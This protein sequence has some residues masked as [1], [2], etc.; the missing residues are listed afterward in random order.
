MSDNII[1][2]LKKIDNKYHMA[3]LYFEKKLKKMWLFCIIKHLNIY[4]K[5][6]DYI[7]FDKIDNLLL[8]NFIYSQYNIN[9][10]YFLTL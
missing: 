1:K 8:I 7:S 9:R 4:K 6:N 5:Y 2:Y 3:V 10:F